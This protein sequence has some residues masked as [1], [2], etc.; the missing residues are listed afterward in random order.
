VVLADG[1]RIP[2][3]RVLI[4][5]GVRNRPWPDAEQSAL[6]GVCGVRT[7]ADAVNLARLLAER[8]RRVIVIGGGFT[9]SEIAS[10]CRRRGIDVTVIERASAPLAAAL[11]GVVGDVA[12]DLHRSNGVDLR[13]R[14][15]VT[16]LEGSG[17]RFRAAVLSDGSTVAADV[18]VIALGAVRNTE[19]LADSGLAVGPLGVSTDSGCRAIAVNGL[20]TEIRP[21]LR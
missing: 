21:G 5:T 3:D 19:W 4:A 10:G 12:A 20:V 13:C 15:T 11:G 6:T 1:S 2:Y 18:A 16:A 14:V 8:P 17:G 7:R 9:G